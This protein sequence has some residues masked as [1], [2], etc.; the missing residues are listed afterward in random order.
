M[1]STKQ[2]SSARHLKPG[3][4]TPLP[5]FFNEDEE[6]N[7]K[8]YEKHLIHVVSKGAFPVC[9]GSLGEAVHLSRDERII[10]IRCTRQALDK[11]GFESVPIV[12]GVGGSSTRETIQLAQDAASAGATVGMVIPP[13]YYA[14]TLQQ[15][16]SQI[17]RYYIDICKSSPIPLLLYNFPANSAGQDL[18]ATSIKTIMEGF[19]NL[20]G[21]KLTC[22]GR[23]EKL[24]QAVSLCEDGLK[25]DFLILDGV[26]HDLPTWQ[27]FG[28]HGTVS[29]IS[30]IAP[31]STVRLWNLCCLKIRSVEQ[32]DE[33]QEVLSVL[34]E[35]DAFVMPLGV[36][37]LNYVLGYLHGYGKKPRRPLLALDKTN[38][39]LVTDLLAKV[40]ILEQRYET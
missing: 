19:S 5:T 34:S 40:L 15:D 32:D 29:G 39:K 14:A 22:P 16:S 23:M 6:L 12:A 38:G 1:L 11:Q 3:V 30:N 27:V 24:T 13:A 17:E 21:L 28:G 33:L 37:G 7:L 18:S 35:V 10:L 9:A 36:R 26:M 31:S 20:C 8:E 25:P 4:Y 2:H